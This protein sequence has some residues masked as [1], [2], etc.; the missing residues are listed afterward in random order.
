M[1]AIDATK[2]WITTTG[3]PAVTAWYRGSEIAR[4]VVTFAVGFAIGAVML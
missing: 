2:A 1:S 3:W 4:H